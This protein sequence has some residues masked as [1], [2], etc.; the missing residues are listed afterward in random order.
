MH[1]RQMRH[2]LVLPGERLRTCATP[3]APRAA[4]RRTPE[5][6]SHARETP[7]DREVV[8]LEVRHAVERRV[9][10]GTAVGLAAGV[11]VAENDADYH[12]LGERW[13]GGRWS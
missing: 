4:I 6:A 8:P 5:L 13:G 2:H 10:R 9:A 12:G 11:I 3:L 1:L 7:V